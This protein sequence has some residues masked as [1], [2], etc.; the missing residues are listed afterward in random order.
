LVLQAAIGTNS[1]LPNEPHVTDSPSPIHCLGAQDLLDTSFRDELNFGAESNPTGSP[2]GGGDGYQDIITVNAGATYTVTTTEELLAALRDV[3]SGD[4]IYIDEKAQIDLADTPEG[5]IIPGGVTLASNRGERK[6]AG[7]AVYSFEI[8]EPGEYV[9]WGL[10]SASS[11]D[12]GSFWISVDRDEFQQWDIN[13]DPDWNWSRVGRH[14][15]SSGRHVLTV[16]WRGDNSKLDT[17]FVTDRDSPPETALNEHGI[18]MQIW[19][20][21]ESA[22][23]SPPMKAVPDPAASGGAYI[24]VPEGSGMGEYPISPGG[25]ISLGSASPDRDYIVGLI[26]GGEDIRITGLRIE[27]PHKTTSSVSPTTI[28]II[29]LYRN[30]EVDNCEIFGWGNAAIGLIGTGGADMKTGGYIH[31]NYIHHNQM[32]GFGYGVS[33][34]NGAVALIEANYFDYCRHGIA[35]AGDAGDGYEARYNICGPNWFGIS[36]HNFDMHGKPNPNGSG[37]IAGD[38][39]KIHHNTFLGTTSDMPTCIAIRGMPRDGAY[40]DHNWFYFTR[41][42]PVWQTGGRGNVSVTDNLIGEDKYFSASGPI[43]YY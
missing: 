32:V 2:I 27:G 6:A 43:K 40:I 33:V 10:A 28:G 12:D 9:F 17:I 38:T 35:G 13:A 3:N 39:I 29:S 23:L 16:Q 25:K 15:L 19:M 5:A 26:I 11:E 14:Y 31:H 4:T 30:L 34:S 21:G 8:E 37:T 36:P 41:D 18:A 42:A 20:E 22:I 7:S 1:S 24:S